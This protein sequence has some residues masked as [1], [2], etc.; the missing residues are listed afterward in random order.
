M[1][2]NISRFFVWIIMGLVLIGLVGFGSF[3]FGGSAT[4]V[5]RVG[6][7]EID[8]SAYFRELNA[9][10]RAWQAQTGQNL[11][12]AQAQAI[13]LD[14]QVL[15]RVV[16]QTALDN[17][18]TNIGISVG[19]R[20][21]AARVTEIEAFQNV[22]GNFDR[23]TYDFVL[24]QSGL[25]KREFEESLRADVARTILAGAVTEGV[26]Q[27]DIFT[28]T[29]FGW[30]RETRDFTWAEVTP[31]ALEDPIPEPTEAELQAY[32]EAHP[33]DFTTPETRQITYAWLRPEDVI[34]TVPL[35][36]GQLRAAYD[37]RIDDYQL[38]ERRLVERLV[39][40]TEEDAQAAMDRIKAGETS[41]D[42]EVSAR[43]L[44]V[45]DVDL[46]DVTVDDLGEAG[47]AV[48][49][50]DGPGVVGPLPTNL[51]PALYRMNAIL[52]AK[53]TSFEEVRDT[54]REEVAAD[55]ARRMVRSRAADL[56]ELLAGGLTLEE[57]A[58]EQD[59]PLAK[60]GY[61]DGLE[62]GIAAYEAFRTAATEVTA[63]DFPE[64]IELEDGSLF[65][66]RL[67]AVEPPALQPLDEVRDA[68][69]AGWGA[70]AETAALRARAEEM[71]AAFGTGESPATMGLTE[72]VEETVP[73]TGFIQGVPADLIAAAFEAEPGEWQVVEGA[74]RV[75]VMRVDSVNTPE[76][77]SEEA[78]QIKASY[79]AQVSQ[80]LGLE[81]QNAFAAAIE[82]EA[83]VTIDQTV[84]NAVHT[85]FP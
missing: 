31:L 22:S 30:A 69:E 51:G 13:G 62:D 29:L 74:G 32:Y 24:D 21:L 44:S 47:E 11:T 43:G 10:F 75:I 60:I 66:L 71:I 34:A 82:A 39:F 25:T 84:I 63:D 28:E 3:N 78:R 45:A 35:D 4:A 26:S 15:G 57:L 81:L 16:S 8:A 65:A 64:V 53:N 20:E 19:D 41:F 61:Y 12:M 49:A 37:E 58:Q 50:M 27:P 33:E 38:P 14:R 17:E 9:E 40:G 48:F 76:Q 83:G 46:G 72:V 79:A 54:L 7:T 56:D 36:E 85:N 77:D 55:E 1:V 59:I 23:E 42:D 80:G 5:G 73:R 18:T 6:K 70:E 52:P 67:D 68:V 2:S